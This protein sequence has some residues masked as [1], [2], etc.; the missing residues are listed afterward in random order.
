MGWGCP[1]TPGTG[2]R[3]GFIAR[4]PMTDE[5]RTFQ[6]VD[7]PGGHSTAPASLRRVAIKTMLLATAVI[8][9]SR[10]DT[11]RPVSFTR[12]MMEHTRGNLKTEGRKERTKKRQVESNME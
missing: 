3:R 11:L 10:S 7:D 4:T 8:I 6:T 9:A 2:P 12:L 5:S 1:K